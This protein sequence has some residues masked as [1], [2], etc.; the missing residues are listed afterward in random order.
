MNAMS[1]RQA[2]KTDPG[3]RDPQLVSLKHEIEIQWALPQDRDFP[4]DSEMREWVRAALEQL[5]A[6]PV[7]VCVRL[8]NR[9]EIA[10]LNERYRG[11]PAA[12]NVLSFPGDGQDEEGRALLGDIALCTDVVIEEARA[13]GKSLAAHA[14]H[15]LV[16]GVLHLEGY[17]HEEDQ[18]A[19][20]ME[21]IEVDIL[22]TFGFDNPYKDTNGAEDES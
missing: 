11:K 15:M 22:R 3:A 5:D 8:M 9:D 1:P 6:P 17:D 16:H 13:Q 20:Q 19:H 10:G 14:A 21:G 18:A 2:G 12:T 4:T 7:A